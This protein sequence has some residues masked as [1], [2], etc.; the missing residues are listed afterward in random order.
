MDRITIKNFGPI[1][2]GVVDVNRITLFCGPQGSGKST[3]A[4]LVSTFAWL[5]KSLV[6]GENTIVSNSPCQ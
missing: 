5:E 1:K 3:V 6:R 2:N 4:K